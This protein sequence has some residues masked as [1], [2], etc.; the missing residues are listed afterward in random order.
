M[1]TF[2]NVWAYV[3]DTQNLG[4]WGL[5]PLDGCVVRNTTSPT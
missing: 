5:A 4:R 2:D 3:G 1:Q